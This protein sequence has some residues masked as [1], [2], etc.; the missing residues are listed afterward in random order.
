MAQDLMSISQEA[1]QLQLGVIPNKTLLAMARDLNQE[2]RRLSDKIPFDK[3]LD[4]ERKQTKMW[5]ELQRRGFVKLKDVPD[6]N[7]H[8]FGQT[9][10]R[11]Y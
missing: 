11:Y 1:F 3:V 2:I 5:A 7:N 8:V 4:L 10:K 9:M 6:F